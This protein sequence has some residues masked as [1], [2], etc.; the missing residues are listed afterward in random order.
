MISAHLRTDP[1]DP[2]NTNHVP[3]WMIALRNGLR[4]IGDQIETRGSREERL[5]FRETGPAIERDLAFLR[6]ADRARSVSYFAGPG[7]VLRIPHQLALRD[8]T[9]RWDARPYIAPLVE[10]VER[11][12]ATGLVLVGTRGRRTLPVIELAPGRRI[13]LAIIAAAS[14]DAPVVVVRGHLA[15]PDAVLPAP[16]PPLRQLRACICNL[17]VAPR[18]RWA[19]SV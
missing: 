8:D 14:V 10:L 12:R 1:R 16:L 9:V 19:R 2:A 7:G 5:A 4:E 3:A 18:S 17:A 13:D 11:G 6:R 15:W